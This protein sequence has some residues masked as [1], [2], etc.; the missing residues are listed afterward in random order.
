MPE[1]LSDSTASEADDDID[2]DEIDEYDGSYTTTDSGVNSLDT[3]T[4][5]NDDYPYFPP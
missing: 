1:L 5:G 2:W 3:S 4:G